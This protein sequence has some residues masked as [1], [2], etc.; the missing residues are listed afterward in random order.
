MTAG[1]R[2]RPESDAERRYVRSHAG[3]WE[4]DKLRCAAEKIFEV[5]F[6]GKQAQK[7][8]KFGSLFRR[9]APGGRRL[10]QIN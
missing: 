1:G 10:W 4:R 9:H 6:L 5:E 3:A 8:T 2:L 7:T